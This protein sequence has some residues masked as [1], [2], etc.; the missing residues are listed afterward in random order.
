MHTHLSHMNLNMLVLSDYAGY[1]CDYGCRTHLNQEFSAGAAEPQHADGIHSG[2]GRPRP[3]TCR[4]EGR[5]ESARAEQS[6]AEH[7]KA[8]HY[9]TVQYITFQDSAL[10]YG[11]GRRSAPQAKR[12]L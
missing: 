8:Q 6:R 5:V 9:I 7:S 10:Q 1:K 12:I 2:P 3:Q 4:G 11:I